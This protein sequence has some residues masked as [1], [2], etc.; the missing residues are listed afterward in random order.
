MAGQERAGIYQRPAYLR[1]E[2]DLPDLA[3]D[4]LRTNLQIPNGTSWKINYRERTSSGGVK[5]VI[6]WIEEIER[7]TSK[8]ETV[9]L[10]QEKKFAVDLD[11]KG[12]ILSFR[13]SVG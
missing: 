13:E 4:L 3:A 8:G 5:F 9:R 2:V 10:L 7:T 11:V 12:R 1:E 6:S